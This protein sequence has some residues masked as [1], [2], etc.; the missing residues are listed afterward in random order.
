MI[1]SMRERV[2]LR[3]LSSDSR[4]SLLSIAKKLNCS[5]ATVRKIIKRLEK[6]LDI[7]FTLELDLTKL[8]FLQRHIL[9]VKFSKTS[10]YHTVEAAVKDEKDVIAAYAT[11][12]QYDMVVFAA[13]SD[14]VKYVLWETVFV[15]KLSD[16]GAKVM[17]SDLPYFSFGFLPVDSSLMHDIKTKMKKKDMELLRLLNEN[18]RA[19][20]SELARRLGTNESTVR[21][22]VFTMVRSGIIK[23]FTIA[24]QNPP[25]QYVIGFF[26]N[27]T[28]TRAFEKRALLDRKHMMEIDYRLPLLTTF[29]MSAPLT[30]SYANFIIGLFDTEKDALDNTVRKHREIYRTEGLE[31]RHA[32]ITGTLKGLFPFRN[33]DIKANYNVVKWE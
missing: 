28:Y 20:Y 32:R 2:V 4:A 24:V 3:E 26:E 22:K 18:S 9:L 31:E 6:E 11:R 16:Y 10:D 19:S 13:E 14:P 17:S 12:G 8:G 21:Y 27:W 15:Q 1:A 5:Y 29:Q 23:R 25:Q 30:G 7:R 33:L